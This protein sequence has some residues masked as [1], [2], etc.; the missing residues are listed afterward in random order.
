MLIV[1]QSSRKSGI[2]AALVRYVLTT[3]AQRGFKVCRL[4]VRKENT[5]ALKLYETMGFCQIENRGD[6]YLMEAQ[7][8][9]TRV[10]HE[11]PSLPAKSPKSL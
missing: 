1:A 8:G 6:K 7:A 9:Q 3:T 4:E 2:G 10:S 5:A 11:N